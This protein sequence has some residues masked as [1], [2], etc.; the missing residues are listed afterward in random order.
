MIEQNLIPLVWDWFINEEGGG[1]NTALMSI[2]RHPDL[3]KS[4][5]NMILQFARYNF[6]EVFTHGIKRAMPEISD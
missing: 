5:V 1:L 6:V 2:K 4:V 3:A